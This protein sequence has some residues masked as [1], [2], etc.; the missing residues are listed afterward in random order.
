MKNKV[1]LFAEISKF[2]EEQRLVYGY[3][4]TEAL[5]CQG[6]RVSKAAL[7]EALPDYLKFSNIREMHQSSAV[8]VAEE[9]KL[10]DKGLYLVAK[11]VDD[12][13]WK[14]VKE[15]VY[16]G[17]SIGGKC[18]SKMQDMITKMKLTEI[19][20]VDRPANPEAVFDVYKSETEE[21]HNVEKIEEREDVSPKEGEKKYGKVKFADSKNKKYPIDT[22]EH[23]RAAWNY[24]NKEKNAEKYSDKD[25]GTIKSKILAAWKDKIGGQPPSVEKDT[26][27]ADDPGLEKGMYEVSTL[28]QAIAGLDYLEDAVAYEA[29]MEGD[30]STLPRRLRT[31]VKNL[32]QI[33]RDMVDEE[34]EEINASN[35]KKSE[36]VTNLSK[37]EE[38]EMNEEIA[39][40]IAEMNENMQKM[41]NQNSQLMEQN[42]ELAKRVKEMED[43]PSDKTVYANERGTSVISKMQDTGGNANDDLQAQIDAEKDNEE[44]AFLIIKQIH[45]SG[46]TR[47]LF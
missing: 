5:D 36:S 8:G 25:L 40:T 30:G 43:K 46:G 9:A 45:S 47:V 1:N 16:K 15:G 14:K 33:L 19:S 20:L 23:I 3:A 12:V 29:K 13:A 7:Q 38:D 4:S 26:K 39:K 35:Q 22:E 34:V 17:F 28:A 21:A 32:G 18:I 31:A 2:D 6:E 44:K 11:V 42:T 41:L 37:N 24:I 10:D 27:K